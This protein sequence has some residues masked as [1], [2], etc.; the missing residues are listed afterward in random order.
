MA[1]FL[2]KKSV[3][4][5]TSSPFAEVTVFEVIRPFI[6]GSGNVLNLC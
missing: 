4:S 6:R 1:P 2:S 5:S 3:R